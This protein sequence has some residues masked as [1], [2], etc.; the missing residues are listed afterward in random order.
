MLNPKTM[1]ASQKSGV[2]TNLF[3]YFEDGRKIEYII[4]I[5]KKSVNV[6][7]DIKVCN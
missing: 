6:F 3:A 7:S 2:F 4:I 1:L 5:Y